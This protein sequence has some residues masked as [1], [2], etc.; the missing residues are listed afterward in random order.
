MSEAQRYR[1]NGHVMSTDD[2]GSW[3]K[4]FE[5][6]SLRDERD[7]LRTALKSIAAIE[8]KNA[9]T[10][11]CAYTAAM[12]ANAALTPAAGGTRHG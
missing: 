6:Q 7:R 11:G 12:A 8:W 9:A 1:D 4:H 5:Y 10:N 3:V 2:N